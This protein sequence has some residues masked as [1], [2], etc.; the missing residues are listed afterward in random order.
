MDSH[1]RCDER[2]RSGPS[3]DTRQETTQMK[4]LHYP[5]VTEAE[6]SASLQD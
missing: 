2:T 6:Y 1:K 5:K 4:G 3:N